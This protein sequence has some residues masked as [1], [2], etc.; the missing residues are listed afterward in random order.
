M[1]RRQPWNA[2][3]RDNKSDTGNHGWGA[4][5]ET[6]TVESQ[7]HNPTLQRST[8]TLA[9]T[10]RL[11]ATASMMGLSPDYVPVIRWESGPR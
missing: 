4:L 11:L 6:L 2:K 7:G 1:I 3:I 9:S 10:S 8:A 5:V